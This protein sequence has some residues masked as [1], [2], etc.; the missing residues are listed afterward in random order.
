MRAQHYT[1]AR[2]VKHASDSLMPVTQPPPTAFSMIYATA[3]NGLFGL[4]ACNPTHKEQS[5]TYALPWSCKHDMKW[6]AKHTQKS[7][8]IMGRHT[9][10][11]LPN[12]EP[13]K[14][15]VHI[16]ISMQKCINPSHT[17]YKLDHISA[18][19]STTIVCPCC[20]CYYVSNLNE[21]LDIGQFIL[22]SSNNS[23]TTKE[24]S[25]YSSIMVIGG[26]QL[27]ETALKHNGL[28]KIY[29]TLIHYPPLNES[30]TSMSSS[31]S[32]STVAAAA[33]AAV[34]SLQNNSTISVIHLSPTLVQPSQTCFDM[35]FAVV[36]KQ[37][38]TIKPESISTNTT[39]PGTENKIIV[40][41]TFR[42]WMKKSLRLH[43]NLLS[44]FKN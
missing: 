35:I 14:D 6:F 42:I 7:I 39:N 16:V 36:E 20:G 3:K 25:Q 23:K 1:S 24:L 10:E 18:T 11:S 17:T 33:A 32:T 8:L 31:S 12:G 44:L 38:A 34:P 15:R 37:C 19:V 41:V 13:L 2:D 4:K 28:T 27:L 40:D 30:K 9:F 26:A 29:Q 5:A 22:S 21:A 43:S